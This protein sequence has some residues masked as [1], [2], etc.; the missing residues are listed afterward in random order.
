MEMQL[1]DH[2][3]RVVGLD[4][5]EKA[6][7]VS[8]FERR[9]VARR[10]ALFGPKDSAGDLVFVEK[11]LLRL[12]SVDDEGKDKTFQ[13]GVEGCWLADWSG[14]GE[15]GAPGFSIQAI[16]D[17]RVVLIRRADY[18][19]LLKAVPPL[20]R[21]FRQ[22]YQRAHKA[23]QRRARLRAASSAEETY[24]QFQRRYRGFVQRVPQY[25]LASFLGFSP[26]WLSK[27]RAKT[28]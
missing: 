9:N 28:S 5:T 21:Y 23:A 16:E 25:M 11:G 27:I 12:Y 10:A 7:L 26:E 6:I 3:L 15:T 22:V 19:P 2:I 20:E 1:T 14:F 18:E 24:R 13:F 8:R 17:S 4:E